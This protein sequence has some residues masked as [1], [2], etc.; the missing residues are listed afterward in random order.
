LTR[1]RKEA[2]RDCYIIVGIQV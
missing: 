2:K 1:E